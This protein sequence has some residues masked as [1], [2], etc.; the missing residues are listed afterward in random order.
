MM[1]PDPFPKEQDDAAAIPYKKFIG[2][3]KKRH[4]NT[5]SLLSR[6]PYHHAGTVT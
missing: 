1:R 5:A 4:C 3:L 6:L 2:L